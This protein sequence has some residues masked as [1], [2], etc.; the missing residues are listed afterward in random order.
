MKDVFDKRDPVAIAESREVTD[1]GDVYD[2]ITELGGVGTHEA[3]N[4]IT[5]MFLHF[6]IR[7]INNIMYDDEL[8]VHAISTLKTMENGANN[9]F[10]LVGAERK[11]YSGDGSPTEE[12]IEELGLRTH[13]QDAM[14]ALVEI[15][16]EE[17]VKVLGYSF[18]SKEEARVAV[19]RIEGAGVVAGV[20]ADF[21]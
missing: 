11:Y 1:L 21:D 12:E 9:I 5:H 18:W 15:G 19:L 14:E 2:L 6:P 7:D 20:L 17:A 10:Y 16:S 4:A 13:E 8:I 3:A